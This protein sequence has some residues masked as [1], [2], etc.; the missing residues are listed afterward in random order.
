ML[1]AMLDGRGAS[2][3][4][5]M[6]VLAML[7]VKRTFFFRFWASR[8][9]F[10]NQSSCLPIQ[11]IGLHTDTVEYEPSVFRETEGYAIKKKSYFV[12]K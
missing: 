8:S 11:V 3:E 2:R 10:A 9:V 7:V 5:L 6:L 4:H 1:P 12:L